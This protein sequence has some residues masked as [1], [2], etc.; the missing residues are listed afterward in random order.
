MPD[1]RFELRMRLARLQFSPAREAEV[2][3][4]ISPT[5]AR[6]FAGVSLLLAVVALLAC[7]IPAR[8][9]MSVDPVS[10]LKGD[11]RGRRPPRS[12]LVGAGNAMRPFPHLVS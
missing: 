9:A 8:R 7:V 4:E 12:N 10:V 2:I 6:T 1:W 5:D 11:W 3:D